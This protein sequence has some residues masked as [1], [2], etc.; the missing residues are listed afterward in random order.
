MRWLFKAAATFAGI[1]LAFLGCAM[2]YSTVKGYTVWFGRVSRAV[3]TA[4]GK[5]IRGW[6]HS[7]RD[8]QVM[9]FTRADSN[10]PATYDLVFAPG[11][12]NYVI[13]CGKWVAPRLPFI[14]VGDVGPPCLF[15]DG[16]GGSNLSRAERSVSFV[17][18]DGA[19]LEA[20]W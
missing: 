4:E 15:G 12:R 16:H 3:I 7:T 10:K 17:A 20:H 5:Q 2:T 11:G 19:K 1:V 18:D 8:G 14:P 13:G 9:F 6:L